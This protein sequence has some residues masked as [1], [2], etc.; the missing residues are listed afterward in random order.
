VA[1]ADL[2]NNGNEDIFIVMGG[3]DRGDQSPSRL[4]RNPGGHGNN[5]ITIRLAGVKSNR[6]AIGARIAVT[7]DD[8][9]RGRRTIYRTVG[10]GGSFG[11]SPLEQHIGIGR[12][13]RIGKIDIWWPASKTHQTFSDV[14]PNQFLEI[15]EFADTVTTLVRRSFRPGGSLQAMRA[16]R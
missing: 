6:S 14:A 10:S 8:P 7:V 12:A 11:A 5:W 13:A 2:G 1:F 15:K 9:D 4:F 3:P 16:S